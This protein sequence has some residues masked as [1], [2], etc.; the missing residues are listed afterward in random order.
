M[1]TRE[2]LLKMN[3]DLCIKTISCLQLCAERV[4]EGKP[5]EAIYPAALA[6]ATKSK[7]EILNQILGEK[8]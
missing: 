8:E 2:E 3:E 1:K 7:I 4:L 5:E 6:K